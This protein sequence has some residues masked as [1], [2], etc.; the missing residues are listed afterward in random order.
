MPPLTSID[1]EVQ[2]YGPYA[3]TGYSLGSILA[4]EVSKA[5]EAQGQEVRF[6]G[7]IDYS[8]H[9]KHHVVDLNWVDV[10]L[11]ISF[12]LGL[13]SHD[14]MLELTPTLRILPHQE[15]ISHILSIGCKT[16]IAELAMDAEKLTLMTNV[17]ENFR[18]GVAEYD[19]V[20]SVQSVDVFVA[21][22]PKYAARDRRDW[23]ENKL[24][25]WKE[26]SREEA[27]FWDCLGIHAQMLDRE[28]V[29]D[30]SKKLK[31]ALRARGI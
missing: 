21:D 24:G 6:C 28:Y 26:F 4:F 29:V 13:I 18:T 11:H 3:I 16:R 1:R 19:P 7:S 17:G 2:P 22:P 15:A 5:L 31:A 8:P 14:L 12:F 9:V 27:T 20:G 25:K 23:K 10:L 30:F